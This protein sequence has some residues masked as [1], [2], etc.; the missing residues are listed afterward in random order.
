VL[1]VISVPEIENTASV[2]YECGLAATL[3]VG[4]PVNLGQRVYLPLIVK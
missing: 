4:T 2:Y 1:D 3:T